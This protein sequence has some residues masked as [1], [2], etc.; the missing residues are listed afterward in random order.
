MKF[1][2]QFAIDEISTRW[3][4]LDAVIRKVE[5][6][7]SSDS[8]VVTVLHCIPRVES[9]VSEARIVF[10]GTRRFDFFWDDN[11]QF[12]FIPSFTAMILAS[13]RAYVSL[14][15]YDSTKNS[16]DTRDCGVIEADRV[17]LLIEEVERASGAA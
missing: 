10:E 8:G 3:V 13:G 15:P 1:E 9:P 11:D 4:L 5:V 12:Y 14:D 7:S 16:P 17:S 6:Q 2:G